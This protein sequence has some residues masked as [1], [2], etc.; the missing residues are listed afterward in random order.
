MALNLTERKI[1][2]LLTKH[3]G[4]NPRYYFPLAEHSQ[5][6]DRHFVIKV[7]FK[8]KQ[9]EYYSLVRDFE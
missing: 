1:T 3:L 8:G 7:A 9:N 4:F 5:E 2:S 6:T